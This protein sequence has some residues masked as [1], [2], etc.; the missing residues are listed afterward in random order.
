MQL[1]LDTIANLLG[2]Q[3]TYENTDDAVEEVGASCELPLHSRHHVNDLY[4]LGRIGHVRGIQAK[5]RQ[6]EADDP[7]SKPFTTHMQSLVA[8]FDLKRYMN[9]LETLRNDD[10]L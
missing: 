3:W 5:L 1:L 4:Q 2:L 9:V 7:A 10:D 6:I 8:N